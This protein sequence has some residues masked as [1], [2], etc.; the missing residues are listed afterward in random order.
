[1]RIYDLIYALGNHRA[2]KSVL[3]SGNLAAISYNK[4][5]Y[6]L[7]EYNK[8]VIFE[9]PCLPCVNERDACM[10]DGMDKRSDGDAWTKTATTYILVSNLAF[11]F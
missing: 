9:L 5:K 10:L 8:N 1:M 3:K 4:I 6:L 2:S 7:V 11:S